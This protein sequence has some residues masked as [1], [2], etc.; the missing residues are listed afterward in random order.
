AAV[1]TEL[2]VAA[3][4]PDTI[5]WPGLVERLSAT[6]ARLE[7]LGEDLLVLAT[8]EEQGN[9]RRTQVDPDDILVRPIEPP[10]PGALA[11]N[12]D[13]I[14]GARVWGDRDQPERVVA[15][16][17]DNAQRHAKSTVAVELEA[18]GH[19]AELFVTDDGPGVPVDQR[20]RVF[21][22]FA[23]VDDGR[24]RQSG[25]AGLGLAIARRI[26]EGHGG[27]ISIA[28]SSAG[29][30]LVGRPPP[31]HPHPAPPPPPF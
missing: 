7:R 15:N 28:D 24:D 22:R 12:L 2:D 9:R 6:N 27:T 23:R 25:G 3:A 10:A 5:D 8:A 17:L 11:I 30:P 13:H 31:A 21:D 1:R 26:V 29:T 20:A 4:H 19:T 14:S 18:N 16:V